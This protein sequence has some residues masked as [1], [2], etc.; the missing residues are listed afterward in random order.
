MYTDV[1]ALEKLEAK[2][3]RILGPDSRNTSV[4][5]TSSAPCSVPPSSSSHCSALPSS[6]LS[7][8]LSSVPT[9][10]STDLS[11]YFFPPVP[12][13][14]HP[15]PFPHFCDLSPTFP[16]SSSSSAPAPA[17]TSPPPAPPPSTSL[18]SVWDYEDAN[19]SRP[20]MLVENNTEYV[21]ARA[22]CVET[23]SKHLI[24]TA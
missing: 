6:I 22:K 14:L 17:P 10:S 16:S 1:S 9:S 2:V 12:I 23:H 11:S 7:S 4:H 19:G 8:T 21:E 15:S 18:K 5:S 13:P 24:F 3:E 20:T